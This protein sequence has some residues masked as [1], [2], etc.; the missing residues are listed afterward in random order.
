[1]DAI[2]RLGLIIFI[3]GFLAGCVAPPATGPSATEPSFRES[4]LEARID[5]ENFDRQL[6]AGAIFRETNR[7]RRQ[8]GLTPFRP[9]VKLNEAADLEAAVGRVYQPPSHTNPFPAIGTPY[10]RVKYAGL[11]PGLVAENIA[12]LS[13]YDISPAEGVG[14]A[15]GNGQKRPVNPATGEPLVAATYGGFARTVVKAWM[16]SPGHRAHLIHPKLAYLGCST[17]PTV[18]V[19]GIHQL[20]CVQVFFTPRGQAEAF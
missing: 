3:V 2:V 20:F 14:L 10:E 12:V 9:L 16:N 4:E 15:V 18:S 7:V 1:L 5:V 11:E 8:L 19:L 6:L 13:I 17:Q